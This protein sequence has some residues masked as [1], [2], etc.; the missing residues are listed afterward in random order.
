MTGLA[1]GAPLPLALELVLPLAMRAA[2]AAA[3]AAFAA[4][5]FAST[6]RFTRSIAD[7]ADP[8]PG[9]KAAPPPLPL[10]LS[11]DE[12]A[13]LSPPPPIGRRTATSLAYASSSAVWYCDGGRWLPNWFCGRRRSAQ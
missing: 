1:A 9:I 12:P 4:A 8:M 13:P 10:A 5:T 7:D 11:A 2:A 3:A 6:S